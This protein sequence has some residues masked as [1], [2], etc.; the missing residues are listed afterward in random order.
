MSRKNTLIFPILADQSLSVAFTTDP[1]FCRYLDNL[2]YQ[3][4]VTTADSTGT[5]TVQASTDFMLD[6]RQQVANPG[7]WTD[8]DL[9]GGVPFINAANDT[10]LINLNQV[11]FNAVRIKYTP[12][13]AGTGVCSMVV[14]GKS[15]G[16]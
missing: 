16:G 8:L 3:I 2:S 10:I 6:D 12:N 13:V 1:T 9:D 7:T 5:F 15:L 14:S 11:A 4:S